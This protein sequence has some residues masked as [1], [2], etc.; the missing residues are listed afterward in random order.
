MHLHIAS[1]GP[2][3]R[4]SSAGGSD[5]VS[6]PGSDQ[7]PSSPEGPD[8]AL[9]PQPS[10]RDRLTSIDPNLLEGYSP[11]VV[12]EAL[13][14][15]NPDDTLCT[16]IPNV[17][18]WTRSRKETL[19]EHGKRLVL[20]VQRHFTPAL[21][22]AFTQDLFRDPQVLRFKDTILATIITDPHAPEEIKERTVADAI[23]I[24]SN[25]AGRSLED[26]TAE[27]FE[28]VLPIYKRSAAEGALI[29]A[30]QTAYETC[31]ECEQ[32]AM[33]DQATQAL[34]RHRDSVTKYRTDQESLWGKR[35]VRFEKSLI[36]PPPTVKL[37]LVEWRKELEKEVPNLDVLRPMAAN[38][39]KEIDRWM[40]DAAS[41]FIGEQNSKWFGDL[42][43]EQKQQILGSPL[44]TLGFTGQ[45]AVDRW[46]E[47]II[48]TRASKKDKRLAGKLAQALTKA[49]ARVKEAPKATASP[50]PAPAK[51][52]K[53]SIE[54]RERVLVS[55]FGRR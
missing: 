50:P 10:L 34:A 8:A 33:A 47:I 14:T 7:T 11:R 54:P 24:L 26:S 31:V 12:D 20:S 40:D 48:N 9:P 39:T 37:L 49:K 23:L 18:R 52:S 44:G 3:S 35:L 32:A 53:P 51:E 1:V 27:T 15:F 55:R 30:V 42:T 4:H 6:L 17:L 45:E 41:I 28:G 5:T 22:E 2:P 29:V 38:V 36:D 16:L 43:Q 13:A 46:R 21:A 25:S 19:R